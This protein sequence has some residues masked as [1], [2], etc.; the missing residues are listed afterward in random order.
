ML[1]NTGLQGSTLSDPCMTTGFSPFELPTC[2]LLQKGQ[3]HSPPKFCFV[4]R[5][6]FWL[7]QLLLGFGLLNKVGVGSMGGVIIILTREMGERLMYRIPARC[8]VVLVERLGSLFFDSRRSC[9][10]DSFAGRSGLY[11]GESLVVS[12]FICM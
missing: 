10:E 11:H 2:G 9:T 12:M 4:R 6:A 1:K 3:D 7:A 5:P 8:C